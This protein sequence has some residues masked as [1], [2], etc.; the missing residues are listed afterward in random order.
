MSPLRFLVALLAVAALAAPAAQA[1]PADMHASTAL[2]AAKAQHRQDLGP[3][4]PSTRRRSTMWRRLPSR[5]A[6]LA[7]EPAADQHPGRDQRR[8]RRHRRTHDRPRHPGQPV[9]RPRHYRHR[10]TRPARQAPAR[11]RLK[12]RHKGAGARA[13]TLRAAAVCRDE[14]GNGDHDPHQ[15]VRVASQRAPSGAVSSWWT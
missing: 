2:A 4:T 11:R 14:V 10:G 3:P 5:V 15:R 6:D 7:V 8:R 1:Q 12:A 9:R 13:G